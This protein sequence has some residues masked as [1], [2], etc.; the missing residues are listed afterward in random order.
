MYGDLAVLLNL[1][2]QK[3]IFSGFFIQN[4]EGI[5]GNDEVDVLHYSVGAVILRLLG[6]SRRP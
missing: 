5:E 3:R 4:W 1:A 2:L 6:F